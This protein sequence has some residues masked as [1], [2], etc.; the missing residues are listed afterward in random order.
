MQNIGQMA[1]YPD[2]ANGLQNKC[3]LYITLKNYVQ[4]YNYILKTNELKVL[5]VLF[6]C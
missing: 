6:A 4:F 3:L 5:K 2:V 1:V